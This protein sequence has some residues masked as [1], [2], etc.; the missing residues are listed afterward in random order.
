VKFI[1]PLRLSG[2][3]LPQKRPLRGNTCFRIGTL[4][5]PGDSAPSDTDDG[6]SLAAGT[7][8][9]ADILPTRQTPQTQN[10]LKG[11]VLVMRESTQGQ[12][13]EPDML[14]SAWRIDR[15]ISRRFCEEGA[16]VQGQ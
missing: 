12:K 1:N 7:L 16:R 2:Y 3:F 6:A 9:W 14:P 11:G 10:T 15:Q 4:N 13:S 5:D 8:N